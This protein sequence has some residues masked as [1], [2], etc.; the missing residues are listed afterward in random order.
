MKNLITPAAIFLLISGLHPQA[1]GASTGRFN[2]GRGASASLHIG[3]Y[4]GGWST[5]RPS[6]ESIAARAL[7]LAND[8]R[9]RTPCRDLKGL[10]DLVG[11]MKAFNEVYGDILGPESRHSTLWE[12]HREEFNA[13]LKAYSAAAKEF[14]KM[15]SAKIKKGMANTAKALGSTSEE[16]GVSAGG[17]S[18]SPA[19]IRAGLK[20]AAVSRKDS[21]RELAYVRTALGKVEKIARRL[22]KE[23][24][25]T[26][27]TEYTMAP[28]D[29][30][31]L[32]KEASVLFA[33]ESKAPSRN[34]GKTAAFVLGQV[35][36]IMANPY[37]S[38]AGFRKDY[39]RYGRRA[40]NWRAELAAVLGQAVSLDQAESVA[41][42]TADE[43]LNLAHLHYFP[44]SSRDA[45]D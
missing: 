2:T 22:A 15:R 8:F 10:S 42:R 18:S 6:G 13:F 44:Q 4:A 35:N 9:A 16:D 33:K 37:L 32:V 12:S 7:E 14:R 27:I 17:V 30:A 34:A 38:N 29:F 43:V 11:K 31:D 24:G 25:I 28:R 23:R 5:G 19:K 45:N 20:K 26:K 3:G 40:V 36:R 21:Q 1:R 41:Q 39:H